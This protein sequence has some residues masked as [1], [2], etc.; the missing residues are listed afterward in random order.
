M[1]RGNLT[2]A[3]FGA[4]PADTVARYVEGEAQLLVQAGIGKGGAA[5]KIT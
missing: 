3:A 1:K 4:P 2:S 5:R